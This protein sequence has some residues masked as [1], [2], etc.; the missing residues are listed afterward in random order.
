MTPTA[1]SAEIP[2]RSG[3][4][5]EAQSLLDGDD[6]ILMAIKPSGW[7]VIME[8]WAVL[9]VTVVLGIGAFVADRVYFTQ[10]PLRLMGYLCLGIAGGRTGFA[11]IQWVGCLYVLTTHRVLTVTGVLKVV[12]EES[13]LHNIERSVLS[14]TSVERLVGVGT[15]MFQDPEGRI[16]SSGWEHLARPEEIQE[17]VDQAIRRARPPSRPAADKK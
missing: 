7:Y 17:V 13:S 15:L 11:C 16:P 1:D 8:S 10:I 3:A 14:A 5:A 4:V 9:V 6:V 2:A 12:I